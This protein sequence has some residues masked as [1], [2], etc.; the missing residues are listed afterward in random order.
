MAEEVVATFSGPLSSFSIN[1]TLENASKSAVRSFGISG[2]TA[3]FPV[4]WDTFGAFS[5]PATVMSTVGLDT[6][7]VYVR[8]SNFDPGETLKFNGIDPDF[9]GDA[10]SG[11]RVLD[12]SGARTVVQFA[13]GTSAFGEF[14]ATDKG[15]LQAVMTK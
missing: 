4:T 8:F 7:V 3:K 9:T 12:M 10:S 5:G 14:K 1:L 13:D 15:T 11:V 6:E 2:R